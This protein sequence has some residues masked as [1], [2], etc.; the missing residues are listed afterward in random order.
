MAG[1]RNDSLLVD[2]LRGWAQVDPRA[3]LDWVSQDSEIKHM[4]ALGAFPAIFES[5]VQ[6]DF[7]E[8]KSMLSAIDQED[9]RRAAAEGAF[10]GLLASEDPSLSELAEFATSLSW[11]R[12][13]PMIRMTFS[14]PRFH[15]FEDRLEF[16]SHP[17]EYSPR[18]A[19]MYMSE[20]ANETAQ[21]FPE[22]T[23]AWAESLEDENFKGQA[24]E[25]AVAAWGRIDRE[26]AKQ[27][28]AE[29]ERGPAYDRA[30][31]AF[32]RPGFHDD[33]GGG[34]VFAGQIG[35]ETLRSGT[36]TEIFYRWMVE[37]R[38]AAES[39]LQTDAGRAISEDVPYLTELLP[40]G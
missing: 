29:A 40:N 38:P 10:Q 27:W 26:A 3:A 28:F 21:N 19:D 9:F 4:A 15:R 17:R 18:E 22:E 31:T 11:D 25:S 1:L 6:E 30:V 33:P 8:T 37:D 12:G 5:L 32:I 16:A 13:N 24:L 2:A 23:V 36:Q 39:F 34:M 14:N 7:Q 20:V 35:N